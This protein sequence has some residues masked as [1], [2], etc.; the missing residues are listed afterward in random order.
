MPRPRLLTITTTV[1]IQYNSCRTCLTSRMRS[2]SRHIIPL[3][4]NSLG[5]GH[6]HI[7]TIRT[8]SILR[9][10][11]H[12]CHRPVR[13]WFKNLGYGLDIQIILFERLPLCRCLMVKWTKSHC[14]DFWPQ[15]L[16]AQR[17]YEQFFSTHARKSCRMLAEY[18]MKQV[19]QIILVLAARILSVY[20]QRVY[21][22]SKPQ[23]QHVKI[24]VWK[25]RKSQIMEIVPCK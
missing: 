10:Q 4:I 3:I 14:W 13:A 19:T 24:L 15:S 2:I 8:G 11:A 22:K 25:K 17:S 18:S 1:A 6:T 23:K 5:R 16:K 21:M 20:F 12:A 9:N 7:P